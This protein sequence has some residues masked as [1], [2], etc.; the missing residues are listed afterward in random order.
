[1]LQPLLLILLP[2]ASTHL[3]IKAEHHPLAQEV[4]PFEEGDT[5]APA[6]PP[7]APAAVAWELVSEVRLEVPEGTSF[8]LRS[9]R[10]LEDTTLVMKRGNV[11]HIELFAADGAKLEEWTPPRGQGDWRRVSHG[12]FLGESRDSLWFLPSIRKGLPTP[13]RAYRLWRKEGQRDPLRR[14][15]VCRRVVA[16]AGGSWR[17]LDMQVQMLDASFEV[18]RTVVDGAGE[19]LIVPWIQGMQVDSGGTLAILDGKDFTPTC[20]GSIEAVPFRVHPISPAGEVLRS[21]DFPPA[22]CQNIG[23]FSFEGTRLFFSRHVANLEEKS[24]TNTLHELDLET[25]ESK[26]VLLSDG[27]F[28][29][30]ASGNARLL[31]EGRKLKAFDAKTGTV[32]TYRAVR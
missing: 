23:G 5:D 27:A 2:L 16:R 13:N 3:P 7:E 12:Q 14:E 9:L 4:G 10:F 15:L 21:V 25:G 26:Q 30:F 11:R 8:T 24:V 28:L 19:P 6:L 18:Q 31:D 22:A 20:C 1:M 29:S 32:R 17:G